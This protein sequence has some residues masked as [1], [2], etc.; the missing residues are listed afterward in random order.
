MKPRACPSYLRD[1]QIRRWE[2]PLRAENAREMLTILIFVS[3]LS[4]H[5]LPHQQVGLGE[6]VSWWVNGYGG[7]IGKQP[8]PR[9]TWQD[10]GRQGFAI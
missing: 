7:G 8:F 6:R 5:F 9:H 4:Y 2:D 1:E 10:S 3:S